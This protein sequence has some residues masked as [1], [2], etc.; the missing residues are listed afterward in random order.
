MSAFS[1]LARE[2]AASGPCETKAS[3]R[4]RGNP[5]STR[6]L[7]KV[8]KSP[9]TWSIFSRTTLR[10]NRAF[11]NVQAL[12]TPQAAAAAAAAASMDILNV[13]DRYQWERIKADEATPTQFSMNTS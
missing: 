13:L 1:A 7:K 3:A 12:Q 4:R 6:S 9:A 10:Q 2:N 8:F 11:L 5:A